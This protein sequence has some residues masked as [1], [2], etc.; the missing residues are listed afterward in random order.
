LLNLKGGEGSRRSDYAKDNAAGAK[1]GLLIFRKAL[2]L[3]REIQKVEGSK[4]STPQGRGGGGTEK[5]TG[6]L[7]ANSSPLFGKRV[8]R[9]VAREK[10]SRWGKKKNGGPSRRKGN[11]RRRGGKTE[12]MGTKFKKHG[13][14]C[15]NWQPGG[16]VKIDTRGEMD[17]G[18]G[19]RG[20]GRKRWYFVRGRVST[21][22]K[23]KV[24][25][26]TLGDRK[27]TAGMVEE[28]TRE[29]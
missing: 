18:V 27:T 15:C 23:Q 21:A 9:D 26:V 17:E 14:N 19:V 25:E 1:K 3:Q 28:D 16:K 6:A 7:R 24:F 4:T 5:G 11:G 20:S 13:P 22:T 10:G 29:R 12:P 8:A 2:D